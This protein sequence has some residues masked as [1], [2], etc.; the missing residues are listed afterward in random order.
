M[1]FV[2]SRPWDKEKFLSPQ[3]E[4]NLKPPS[5]IYYEVHVTRVLHTAGISNFHSV[6]FENLTYFQRKAL[7]QL[8]H[9]PRKKDTLIVYT[10][11]G[12]QFIFYKDEFKVLLIK[13]LRRN[14]LSICG[15]VFS[16]IS[17]A[18]CKRKYCANS[19]PQIS[20]WLQFSAKTV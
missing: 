1:F 2:L 7:K 10:F 3:E 14:V 11:E 17:N 18:K 5:N 19:G 15:M 12:L 20:H 9:S 16:T 4:S 6:V 13:N 8:K